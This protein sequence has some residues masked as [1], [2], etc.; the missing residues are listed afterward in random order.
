M[1][2]LPE[3]RKDLFMFPHGSS[4]VGQLWASSCP[5]CHWMFLGLLPG[6]QSEQ[7]NEPLPPSGRVKARHS[8][9]HRAPPTLDGRFSGPGY[10][11]IS[12]MR[13]QKLR[14]RSPM[15]LGGEGWGQPCLE[16]RVSDCKHH[17]LHHLPLS[18]SGF[19]MWVP[20]WVPASS[21]GSLLRPQSCP[22]RP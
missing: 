8:G 10:P 15:W 20:A 9:L 13:E 22:Q 12:Q 1:T 7:V 19:W 2:H 3:K 4:Q 21:S 11:P 18:R 17:T 5:A 16:A 14:R 6:G